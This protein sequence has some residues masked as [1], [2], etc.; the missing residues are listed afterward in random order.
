MRKDSLDDAARISS[1][2]ATQQTTWPT[3]HLRTATESL[4]LGNVTRLEAVVC[5][6]WPPPRPSWS[7][8]CPRSSEVEKKRSATRHPDL[9]AGSIIQGRRRDDPP[10]V[11]RGRGLWRPPAPE[12]W[13]ARRTNNT[14]ADD[15]RMTYTAPAFGHSQHACYRLRNCGKLSEHRGKS[16]AIDMVGVS[17][18][19]STF[20]SS[21]FFLVCLPV[22]L[23]PAC[24]S[25]PCPN[26]VL[27]H[28]PDLTQRALHRPAA[29]ALAPSDLVS[30]AS[31]SNITIFHH[32]C[33][34]L[35]RSGWLRDQLEKTHQSIERARQPLLAAPS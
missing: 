32:G 4:D 20:C 1:P 28:P 5:K 3:Q 35:L 17:V 33:I 18:F 34:E 30:H 31:A 22:C 6:L 15:R 12:R 24:L 29:S 13:G 11:T 2:I 26:P 21:V 8:P 10:P 23:L 9:R 27:L 25:V 14:P 7:R 16:S 19:P